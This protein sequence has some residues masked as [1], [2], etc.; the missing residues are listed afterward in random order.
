MNLLVHYRDAEAVDRDIVGYLG[1]YR[2][3]IIHWRIADRKFSKEVEDDLKSTHGYP[4]FIPTN[5][6]NNQKVSFF[7]GDGH[8]IE[9]DATLHDVNGKWYYQ[10]T[11]ASQ[12][13]KNKQPLG[14][15]ELPANTFFQIGKAFK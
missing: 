7:R 10:L 1:G 15:I 6:N 2:F 13:D 3:V 11:D 5:I 12:K 8:S 14:L 4:I 9:I